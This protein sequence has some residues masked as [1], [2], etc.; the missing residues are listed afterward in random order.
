M[1]ELDILRRFHEDV[2]GPSN[3]AWLRAR[4]AVVAA[5]S[6]S[7]ESAIPRRVFGFPMAGVRRRSLVALGGAASAMVA[8]VAVVLALTAGGA[9]GVA[10]AGWSSRPTTA[11]NGQ[12]QMARAECERNPKLASLKPAL[13]DTRGPYTLLVYTQNAGSLCVAGSS[14][15]SPSGEP[16]VVPFGSFLAASIAA[17]EAHGV[18]PTATTRLEPDAIRPMTKGGATVRESPSAP[19]SEIGLDVGQIG[20]HVTG[21]TLVL[22]DGR[23]I[24]ATTTNGWFAA[25]WPD[26]KEAQAAELTTPTGTVTQRLTPTA[27]P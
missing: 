12:V 16:V 10:F 18:A 26:G 7:A 15:Q 25:W 3:E 4:E 14:M 8:I 22:T 6:Q 1:N 9:P 2:P 27:T 13:V 17:A 11:A 5:R 20:E 24:E 19:S 21:V 23:H